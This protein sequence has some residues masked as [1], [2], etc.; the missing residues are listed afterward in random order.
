MLYVAVWT[1]LCVSNVAEW[2]M[3]SGGLRLFEGQHKKGAREQKCISG[4]TVKNPGLR[5][6]LFHDVTQAL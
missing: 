5:L 4:V 6:K 1:C 2:V 3:D